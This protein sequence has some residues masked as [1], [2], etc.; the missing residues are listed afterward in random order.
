VEADFKFFAVA[1]EE[2]PLKCP[3]GSE[4]VLEIDP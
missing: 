3:R 4:L 2:K 1:G